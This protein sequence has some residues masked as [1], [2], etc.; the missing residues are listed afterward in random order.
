MDKLFEIEE[1]KLQREKLKLEISKLEKNLEEKSANNAELRRQHDELMLCFKTDISGYNKSVSELNKSFEELLAKIES[2]EKEYLSKK[3]ELGETE[4]KLSD[5]RNSLSDT[6]TKYH[7]VSNKYDTLNEKYLSLEKSYSVLNEKHNKSLVYEKRL[8]KAEEQITIIKIEL[9]DLIND[10]I[11]QEEKYSRL[12]DNKKSDLSEANEKFEQ[13]QITLNDLSKTHSDLKED[14]RKAVFEY[15][16]LQ[17]NLF[18]DRLKENKLSDAVK[19]LE[20]QYN[21]YKNFFDS[22]SEDDK[23]IIRTKEAENL[24]EKSEALQKEINIKN[25]TVSRL[26]EEL[27]KLRTSKDSILDE[28]KELRKEKDELDAAIGELTERRERLSRVEESEVSGSHEQII[29]L[30]E[31]IRKLKKENMQKD[32]MIASL[33]GQDEVSVKL[34]K[35]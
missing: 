6:E 8:A 5:I 3:N 23:N 25:E 28:V 22:L 13:M 10:H 26:D 24:I 1:L 27:I 18:N 31:E 16:K 15:E 29:E 21:D 20:K 4:A 33:L 7:E 9:K 14:I 30:Q 2:A 32:Q 19:T 12:I 11:A 17:Q 34:K 35:W